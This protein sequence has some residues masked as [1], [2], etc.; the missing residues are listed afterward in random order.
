MPSADFADVLGTSQM[1]TSCT[2]LLACGMPA[3]MAVAVS[4]IT[5][6]ESM[7]PLHAAV[8]LFEACLVS[9]LTDAVTGTS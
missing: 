1:Y 3:L 7:G 4:C 6:S 8:T 9:I 2:S 5:C